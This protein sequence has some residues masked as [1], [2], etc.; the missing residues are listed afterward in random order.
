VLRK[1]AAALQC[2][3]DEGTKER[4]ETVAALTKR[5]EEEGHE[6]HETLVA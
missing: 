3:S 6:V 4:Q 2:V 5:Y 1:G